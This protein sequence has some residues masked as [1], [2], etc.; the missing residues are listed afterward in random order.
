MSTFGLAAPRLQPRPFLFSAQDVAYY[1]CTAEV[2]CLLS[3]CSSRL[4]AS[5]MLRGSSDRLIASPHSAG[6]PS[7]LCVRR[8][9]ISVESGGL[10]EC[11]RVSSCRRL[12]GLISVAATATTEDTGASPQ[13]AELRISEFASDGN[14]QGLSNQSSFSLDSSATA[15]AAAAGS[16]SKVQVAAAA[17]SLY[18]PTLIWFAKTEEEERQVIDRIINASI[19][20]AAGVYAFTKVFTVDQD[21]WHGWTMFEILK[22]APIHNWAAYEEA[23]KNHPVLAKMMISGIVYSVGDWMAQCYEGKPMLD[24]SRVRMLRSGLVGF[25]LHGSLSHFYYHF[26]EAIFPF[27][28]WWVVPLKVAFDQT[29]WSAFWNSVYYITLG[30]LRLESPITILSELRATFFPLLTAGWKLWPFAHLVT[31]GVIPVEQRLLWVDCVELIWVTILSMYSNKNAE[32]RSLEAVAEDATHL[33]LDKDTNG[34]SENQ[35]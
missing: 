18:M 29:I 8:R 28:D 26:C 33:L 25:C 3:L 7:K 23:L 17:Q 27:K 6:M 20:G 14:G 16:Y 5:A 15:A 1:A 35:D 9:H 22:Y 2:S 4:A 30:L 21:Y 34:F 11:K 10:L 12:P 19:L 13:T 31:Y 32:A 24:F